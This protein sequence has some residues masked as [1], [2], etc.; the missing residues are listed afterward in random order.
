MI[1]EGNHGLSEP[2]VNL[3]SIAIGNGWTDPRRQYKY[4]PDMAA[5]TKYG[6]ILNKK[7]IQFMRDSYHDCDKQE[8]KCYLD[9][10]RKDCRKAIQVCGDM[11]EAF[12]HLEL[13]IYDIRVPTDFYKEQED[14]MEEWL[15]TP[16]VM[17]ALG[18]DVKHKGCSNRV[19][20]QFDK[21]GDDARPVVQAIPDLLESGI[22]ILIYAGDADWICNWYGN[23]AWMMDVE[24]S[25]KE[26][27]VSEPDITWISRETRRPAGEYRRYKNF[28]FLKIFD[29]GHYVPTDM[30][31]ESLELPF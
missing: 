22:R 5:D 7:Q 27:F 20:R 19:G 28:A 14:A 15:N 31:V 30:P 16:S 1:N 9:G 23:K 11:I 25:G 21:T 24:W 10:D 13:S 3:Q 6:P 4:Y 8:T 18:A 17:K 12:D 29:S 2:I 26:G